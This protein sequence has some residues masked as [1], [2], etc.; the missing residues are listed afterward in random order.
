MPQ[1][2]QA[3]LSVFPGQP[4]QIRVVSQSHGI[5]RPNMVDGVDF[6]PKISVKQID[7]YDNPE[8]S[9]LYQTFDGGTGKLSYV[10]SNQGQV[11]AMLMDQD[12]T[13]A[14]ALMDP[15]GYK[16]MTMAM[17]Y[18]GLDGNFKRSVLLKNCLCSGSPVTQ[19]VKDASKSTIDFMF[20]GMYRF[21][22]LAILYTRARGATAPTAAPAAP[23]C[24]PAVTTGT[25]IAGEFYVRI[26]AVTAAGESA[27]SPEVMVA[28]ATG[29]AGKVT[30]TTTAPAGA[31]TG[32]NVY[33]S[34]RSNGERFAGN[35]AGTATF[36]ITALPPLT[37]SLC[38]NT[39]STGVF[40]ATGDKV[41]SG[42]AV[43][44]DKTA[45]FLPQSG[46]GYALVLKNGQVVGSLNQPAQAA[47]FGIKSDGTQFQIF[48][49]PAATDWYDIFT[50]YQP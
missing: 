5:I 48:A 49:A 42:Q 35:D 34:D 28:V 6:T 22:G 13:A 37:A 47:N 50:L 30:V 2:T 16:P 39:D 20:T 33:F 4:T 24:T 21:P 32:Y 3:P 18:R 38:P 25:L 12:P 43:T 17:N 31:I 27:G 11:E 36:V 7:E 10:E 26:T 40:Q 44:L 1:N 9:L 15:V 23:V 45:Y 14:I 46:L 19:T 41:F 8:P 29:T